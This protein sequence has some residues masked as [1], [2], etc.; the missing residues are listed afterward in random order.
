MKTLFKEDL[1]NY[2]KIIQLE[3]RCWSKA[4]ISGYYPKLKYTLFGGYPPKGS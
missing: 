3:R 4:E 1:Y 2:T